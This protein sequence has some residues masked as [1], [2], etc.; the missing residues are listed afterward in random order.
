MAELKLVVSH[1]DPVQRVST[2]FQ[3]Q[4]STTSFM[5]KAHKR[6]SRLYEMTIQDPFH[7][8]ACDLVLEIERNGG[9]T[10]VVCHFPSFMDDSHKLLDEDADLYGTIMIQFQMKVLDH[11]F[12]FSTEHK[13]SQLSIYMDDDQAEGFGIVQGFLIHCDET[14]RAYGEKTEMVISTDQNMLLEWR[15]FMEKMNLELE[16]DMWRQQRHNLVIR[17]YLR[18]RSYS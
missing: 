17:N 9:K 13:A 2:L 16:Q 1:P 5:V 6:G 10:A 8:L 18:S 11:L 7:E 15:T 4:P 12:L 14:I 3:S